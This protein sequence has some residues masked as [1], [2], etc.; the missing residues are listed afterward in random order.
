MIAVRFL[1]WDFESGFERY[2]SQ[3]ETL[4]LETRNR[5]KEVNDAGED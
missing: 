2:N 4:T 5:V 3:L 1:V